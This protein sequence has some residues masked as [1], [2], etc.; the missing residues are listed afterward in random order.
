MKKLYFEYSAL[1]I[2]SEE[3]ITQQLGVTL[4]AVQGLT[5]PKL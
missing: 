1:A 3:Q 5:Q 4:A 2:S